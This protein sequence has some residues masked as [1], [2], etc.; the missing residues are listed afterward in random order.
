MSISG[1]N[2]WVAGA[3]GAG[4]KDATIDPLGDATPN[5]TKAFVNSILTGKNENQLIQGAESTLTSILAREAAYEGREITWGE[6][7]ASEQTWKTDV[8]LDAL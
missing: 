7:L 1:K 3:A 4:A 2:D 6:L 8:D 5:K